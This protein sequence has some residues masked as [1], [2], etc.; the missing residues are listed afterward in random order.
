M[1][2]DTKKEVPH[3]VSVSKEKYVAPN[4]QRRQLMFDSLSKLGKGNHLAESQNSRGTL[5]YTWGAGYHGQLGS[6]T[7]RKKCQRVPSLLEFD[8][9]AVQVACGGFHN[10]LLTDS[11]K[12]Y[13]WG[14]GRHGQLGNLARKHNMLSNPRLV[15]E[16][17]TFKVVVAQ[18]ACGQ[19]HTACVSTHGRLY[20][21]GD[22]KHG[23]LGHGTRLD[24]RYPRIVD[25]GGAG[26]FRKVTCGDRHTCA[27]TREDRLVTFGS[28]QHGQLGHGDGGLDHL[29]PKLVEALT[30]PVIEVDAGATFTSSINDSGVVQ[31]WGFGESLHPKEFSNIVETPRIVRLN[32][33]AKQ[34]AC[35]QSHMLVLTAD[36]D[37]W[38]FG[39]AGMGQIGHGSITNTR[40]P[41]LVLAGKKIFQ[42]A[43]GRYHSMAVSRNGILFSWGCGE[44]GQL[45]HDTLD[46]ELFPRPVGSILANVVGSIS[47]GEHHS[48]CLASIEHASVA[49]DVMEWLAIEEEE[50]KLKKQLAKDRPNGLKTK[51]VI[52]MLTERVKVGQRLKDERF[53]DKEIEERHLKEQISSIRS[54][55][56]LHQEV[57]EGFQFNKEATQKLKD[58]SKSDLISFDEHGVVSVKPPTTIAK[59]DKPEVN[60]TVGRG[61]RASMRMQ[62]SKSMRASQGTEQQLAE[63]H[64]LLKSSESAADLGGK[65]RGTGKKALGRPRVARPKTSGGLGMGG[66][67]HSASAPTLGKKKKFRPKSAG[68]DNRAENTPIATF[69][70][71]QPRMMFME[72]T[73]NTL[74]KLKRFLTSTENQNTNEGS[75][76]GGKSRESKL[77]ELKKKFN[78]LQAIKKKKADALAELRNSLH[79]LQPTEEDKR[80]ITSN[81]KRIKD[82]NMKLVTLNTR[83]MEAEENRKNYELYII[84]MK[85]E[86]VQLS[87]QIDHLRQL[88]TEYD[89]LLTKMSRMNHKVTS[90]KTELDEEIV[91]FHEDIEGFADFADMQLGKYKGIL[92]SNIHARQKAEKSEEQKRLSRERAQ[93]NQRQHIE[94]ESKREEA[95]EIKDEL[96]GWVGK[97]EY[98]EKRFHKITAATGLSRPEDIVNKF[99]FNDEITED[100]QREINK[101]KAKIADL[102]KEKDTVNSTLKEAKGNFKLSKWSDV[103]SLKSRHDDAQSKNNKERADA[104]RL[105]KQISFV[106]EGTE[107]I[108][109]TLEETLGPLPPEFKVQEV[110]LPEDPTDPMES[111]VWWAHILGKRI[112]HLMGVVKLE[113]AKKAEE[114]EKVNADP[115]RKEALSNFA[116]AGFMRAGDRTRKWM[117]DDDETFNDEDADNT[118]PDDVG[119]DDE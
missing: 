34:V 30:D 12:V 33:P 101:R 85:E 44:S 77:F 56:T 66:L 99:F 53:K 24:S 97:V 95:A 114:K 80:I 115:E 72:R 47:C 60:Q 76:R 88:V 32:K 17:A 113:E 117:D 2:T 74:G 20:S 27:I 49:R 7:Y 116:A 108:T 107:Q 41:R 36:G 78:A 93:R 54:W 91:R 87:K 94:N 18:V 5:L 4:I 29:K 52:G 118:Y 11:G 51:D 55:E 6:S 40:N 26:R 62:K 3:Y 28:G 83:L 21:W 64:K 19:Y 63:A 1:A 90:Q 112:E 15:E 23:Q 43:A 73:T 25:S 106:Q 48:F 59:V 16:L 31:I 13:S 38:A 103:G 98:Y 61:Y 75:S 45:A 82:L 65:K 109:R 57:N 70:P 119:F 10:A 14:L 46:N 35:G 105:L 22:G 111:S 67:S 92:D 110:E 50:L 86:D 71:L 79:Y 102:D 8:E 89:R 58:R 69:Q 42:V 96:D 39:N 81:D 68:K 37:V 84:R 100:L 104:A 9:P